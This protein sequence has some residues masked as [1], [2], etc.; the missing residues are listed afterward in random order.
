MFDRNGSLLKY[1][2]YTNT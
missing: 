2:S 1:R